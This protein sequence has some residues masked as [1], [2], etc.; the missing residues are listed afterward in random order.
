[1][2]AERVVG[3]AARAVEAARAQAR[4]KSGTVDVGHNYAAG[5]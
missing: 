2:E 4:G 1:V 5:R 3:H